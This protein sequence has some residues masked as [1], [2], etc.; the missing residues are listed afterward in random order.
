M[1]KAYSFPKDGFA[2]VGPSTKSPQGTRWL[3]VNA[4]DRQAVSAARAA[5]LKAGRAEDGEVDP[6]IR[7][8][9]RRFLDGG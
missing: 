7:T 5:D 6:D 8:T 9:G 2:F 1:L 4:L 3:D